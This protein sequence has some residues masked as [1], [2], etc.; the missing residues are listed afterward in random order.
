[1]YRVVQRGGA[2]RSAR[3]AHNPEVGGSNPPPATIK[4]FRVFPEIFENFSEGFEKLIQLCLFSLNCKT[5]VESKVSNAS[6]PVDPQLI[7]VMPIKILFPSDYTPCACLPHN[8][9]SR[10]YPKT[11]QQFLTEL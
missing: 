7:E 8:S 2:A 11:I 5:N 3:R 1:M 10:V 4:I 9:N 6:Y